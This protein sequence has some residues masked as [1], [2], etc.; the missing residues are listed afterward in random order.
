MI[1]A[2]RSDKGLRKKNEDSFYVPQDGARPVVIV[3]DGMG[4]HIAGEVASSTAALKISDYVNRAECGMSSITLLRQAVNEANRAVF[5]LAMKDDSY[6]GMGTTV[7]MA[8]LSPDRYTVANIGDSRLYHF[9]G[10]K[11]KRVTK[12]HSY[13]QELISAGLITEAQAKDHPQRNLVT[14]AVG[15]SRFE[16]A[17]V[18]VRSWKNGDIL[19]LC[20]DGLCGSVDDKDMER[21]LRGTEDLLDCCDNLT[22]LALM[23]GS[24][25][26]IT[27]VLVKN[28]EVGA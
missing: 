28:A 13:V 4:G 25:D 12:D 9:D 7:V 22:E 3:A 1:Y 21:L 5:E 11:L 10:A 6:S 20:T 26:N 19:M 27:V 18:G 2:Y 15:T 16:K 17:D 24:S 14:R 23:N 8:L